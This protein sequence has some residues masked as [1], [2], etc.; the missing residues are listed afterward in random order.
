[1]ISGW[2]RSWQQFLKK[3]AGTILSGGSELAEI[4][5]RQEILSSSLTE[6]QDSWYPAPIRKTLEDLQNWVSPMVVHS[7]LYHAVNYGF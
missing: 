3:R 6:Q 2:L 7:V 1:M 4:T 5:T